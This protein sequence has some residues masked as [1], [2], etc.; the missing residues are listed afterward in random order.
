M[1]YCIDGI[2]DRARVYCGNLSTNV[3][4][5]DLEDLFDRYGRIKRYTLKHTPRN[6]RTC[7]GAQSWLGVNS[8]DVMKGFAFVEFDDTRDSRV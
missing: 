3:R 1:A 8:C 4:S 2:L 7:A 5:R 6:T